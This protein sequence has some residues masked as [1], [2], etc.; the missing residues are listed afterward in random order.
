MM[1]R[2]SET[3]RSPGRDLYER[4]EHEWIAA[5][6]SALASGQLKRLDRENLIEFLSEM[7]SRDRRELRS[8]LTVPL[9]HLLK[10]RFQPERLSAS[11][12]RT[13]R[14]WQGVRTLS[15]RRLIATP[16]AWPRAKPDCRP[17]SSR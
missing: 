17:R 1:A 3:K 7:T 15:R 2:M 12:G 11:W 9:L 14:A 10:V 4:D 13:F 6:I 8:R 5:Q 16:P